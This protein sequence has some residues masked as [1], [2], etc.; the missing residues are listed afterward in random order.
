MTT[1]PWKSAEA[2]AHVAKAEAFEVAIGALILIEELLPKDAD[3]RQVRQTVH[4]LGTERDAHL[5]LAEGPRFRQLRV[6]EGG[7]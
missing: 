1:K 2:E 6:A 4:L 5:L 7:E 3:I